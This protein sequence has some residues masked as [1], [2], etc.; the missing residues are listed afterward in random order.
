MP[1]YRG[2]TEITNSLRGSTEL[3]SIYRGTDLMW[4]NIDPDAQAF[5]DAAS[6][7]DSTQI[8]AV[9]TFVIGMKAN[10]LWTKLIALYPFVG[11]TAD[12]HKWN[13]KDPQDTNGAF[14]IVWNGTF[15]H[16]S[17]GVRGGG[18]S[19]DYGHPYIYD[20]THLSLGN[21]SLSAYVNLGDNTSISSLMGHYRSTPDR[22]TLALYSNYSG[23]MGYNDS[24]AGRVYSPTGTLTGFVQG[25]TKTTTT[26][27]MYYN[28]VSSDTITYASRP[29]VGY[30]YLFTTF[31]ST[32]QATTARS[33]YMALG[34][35]FTSGEASTYYTLV[36]NMQATLGRDV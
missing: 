2:T 11:G 5:F 29:S 30:L 4:K 36:D 27:E 10:S 18:G 17:N 9:N 32:T 22:K 15:T 23:V 34:E 20:S 26:Y 14:R 8:E 35:S 25:C 24:L 13:L 19:G 28:G 7:T 3:A 1:V 16:D 31:A 6:I 33:G 12:K 21:K